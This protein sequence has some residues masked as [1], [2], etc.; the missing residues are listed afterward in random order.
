M[1]EIL[2][3]IDFQAITRVI[4][5]INAFGKSILALLSETFSWLGTGTIVAIGVGITAA[6][7]LR[8]L[9]R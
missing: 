5:S 8:I 4:E 7:I 1:Q 2:E 3:M 9:G 6:I